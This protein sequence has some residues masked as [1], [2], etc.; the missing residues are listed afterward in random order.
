MTIVGEGRRGEVRGGG[1]SSIPYPSLL[2]VA[3]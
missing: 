1:A 3:G 2:A